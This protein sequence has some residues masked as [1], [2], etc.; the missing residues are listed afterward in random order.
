MHNFFV[1]LLYKIADLSAQV[2]PLQA[3]RVFLCLNKNIIFISVLPLEVARSISFCIII[4]KKFFSTYFYLLKLHFHQVN[5]DTIQSFC[6]LVSFW[7]IASTLLFYVVPTILHKSMATILLGKPISAVIQMRHNAGIG[8]L[9]P[10][11][12]HVS[13]KAKYTPTFL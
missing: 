5:A 8:F 1:L 12:F 2:A 7:K 4:I 10:I 13:R 9:Y 6:I 3:L 11:N